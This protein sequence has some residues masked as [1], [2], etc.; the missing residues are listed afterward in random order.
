MNED[1]GTL[2]GKVEQIVALCDALRA[3]NHRLHDRI[4][5]LVEEKEALAERMTAARTRIEGLMDH[6]PAE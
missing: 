5:V 3:E 4:G 1:L 6:L 2:E